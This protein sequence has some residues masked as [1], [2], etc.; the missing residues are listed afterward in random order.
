MYLFPLFI[1]FFSEFW[2]GLDRLHTLTK[3]G[4]W[5][6]KVEIKYDLLKDGTPSP[7][8]G[9]WGIG[10]WE[11]FSIASEDDFY[12]LNIGTRVKVE[13]MGSHDPFRYQNGMNFTTTDRDNDKLSENCASSYGGGWW[14][15]QC[16]EVCLNCQRAKKDIWY[17]GKGE[18]LSHSLMWIK[19]VA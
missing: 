18:F 16:F 5:N 14:H 10:E 13:N 2:F 9:T 17:D 4:S 11:K 15:N 1:H 19:Q 12:N 6:L 3:S 7:R 8:S